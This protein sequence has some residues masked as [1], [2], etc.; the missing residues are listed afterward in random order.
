M[1]MRPADIDFLYVY[2]WICVWIFKK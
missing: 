2:V 1:S